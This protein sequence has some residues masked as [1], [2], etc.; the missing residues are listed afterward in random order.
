MNDTELFTVQEISESVGT[1]LSGTEIKP[2]IEVSEARRIIEAVLFA[3]GHPV[4]YTR[5]Y[6]LTTDASLQQKK[7]TEIM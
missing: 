5:L 4:T 2:Q 3:A 7:N 6:A 1:D